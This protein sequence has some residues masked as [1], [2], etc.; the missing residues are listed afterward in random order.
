MFMSL[1][2]LIYQDL[3]RKYKYRRF[4]Y[5]FWDFEL[6][7]ANE[8]QNDP[9]DFDEWLDIYTPVYNKYYWDRINSYKRKSLIYRECEILREAKTY[10]LCRFL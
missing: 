2:D 9:Y 10:E 1:A 3:K 7:Y 4:S 6:E 5:I 8:S